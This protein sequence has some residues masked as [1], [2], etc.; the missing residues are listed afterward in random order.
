[1]TSLEKSLRQAGA[2][3]LRVGR[4]RYYELDGKRITL[5]QGTRINRQQ[6]KSLR[7]L[8]KRRKQAGD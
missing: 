3:L 6:E 5:H 1:M 4:H 2:K 7:S 8:L